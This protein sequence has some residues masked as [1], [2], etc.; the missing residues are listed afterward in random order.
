MI[1]QTSDLLN[2]SY[3]FIQPNFLSVKQENLN[4]FFKNLTPSKNKDQDKNYSC[5]QWMLLSLCDND[6]DFFKKL[7][8]ELFNLLITENSEGVREI[9]QNNILEFGKFLK[10]PRTKALKATQKEAHWN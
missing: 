9:N 2:T 3:P 10:L 8:H 4:Q 6:T 1:T 7:R 5:L